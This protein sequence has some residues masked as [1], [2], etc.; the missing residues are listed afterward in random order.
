[1]EQEVAAETDPKQK[2]LKQGL[3]TALKTRAAAKSAPSA[4][5]PKRQSAEQDPWAMPARDE[6]PKSQADPRRDASVQQWENNKASVVRAMKSTLT[7]A[8]ME[9]FGSADM[10][11]P[12]T[13][14]PGTSSDETINKWLQQNGDKIGLTPKDG[15]KLTA[16]SVM[17]VDHEGR[18]ITMRE[19]VKAVMADPRFKQSRQSEVTTA[20][21]KQVKVTVG[22]PR[23]VE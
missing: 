15:G 22:K 6:A 3:L 5:P 11:D 2:Q 9:R 10:S 18:S 7:Q 16:K 8:E 19:V 4:Q 13:G 21:G 14:N 17:F 20:S 1:M 12:A 23:Q